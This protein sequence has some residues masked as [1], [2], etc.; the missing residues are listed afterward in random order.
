VHKVYRPK[1]NANIT[2]TSES[3]VCVCV[4][5]CVVNVTAGQLHHS[6]TQNKASR[7]LIGTGDIFIKLFGIGV[8]FYFTAEPYGKDS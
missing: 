2:H 5:V 3:S 6:F 1:N 4:C 7:I 8:Q